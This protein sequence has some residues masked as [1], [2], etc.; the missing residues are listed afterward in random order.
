MQDMH[1]RNQV[2]PTDHTC[3]SFSIRIQSIALLTVAFDSGLAVI[4]AKLLAI[5]VWIA[6]IEDSGAEAGYNGEHAV[7]DKS[8]KR[9]LITSMIS[10][11]KTYLSVLNSNANRLADEWL[12]FYSIVRKFG[13]KA[14]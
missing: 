2:P 10:T 5:V 11:D 4:L 13:G 3:A 7:S 14:G 6:S 12:D 8:D 1:V 9:S